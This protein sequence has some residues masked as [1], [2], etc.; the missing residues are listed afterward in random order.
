M[1][2]DS[3]ALRHYI[4]VLDFSDL[5]TYYVNVMIQTIHFGSMPQATKPACVDTL[6]AREGP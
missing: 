2:F 6:N 1:G 4:K 3:S 5:L